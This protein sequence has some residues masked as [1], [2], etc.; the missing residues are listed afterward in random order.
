MDSLKGGNTDMAGPIKGQADFLELGDW[1]AVCSMCG[2]KRKASTLVRN[3]QGFMRCPEHNEV[4]HSQDFVR[5][6]PDVQTPPW[7]QPI[8]ADVF[9][10]FP[11]VL[12][13]E[14]YPTRPDD[15]F[16]ATLTFGIATE[17]GI[18]LTTE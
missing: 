9:V 12:V 15:P 4:R 1:N 10:E 3:W 11:D 16:G 14:A 18:L 7:T 13:V 6:V 2:R 17:S 5:A 8:P